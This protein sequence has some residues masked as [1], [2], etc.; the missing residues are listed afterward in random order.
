[1]AELERTGIYLIVNFD[2]PQPFEPEN[3]QLAQE[4]HSVVQGHDWIKEVLTASG[5]LGS[6]QS[7]LWVFWLES[8]A[9]LDRLFSDEQEP[10]GMVY[11]SFFSAMENVDDRIREEVRFQ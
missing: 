8:Y 1:M 9:S 11:R 2:W 4:L 3:G 6:G 10:I 5:G 7:S